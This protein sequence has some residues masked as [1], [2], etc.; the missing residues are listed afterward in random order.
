M[1]RIAPPILGWVVPA[2]TVFL[3][4][5]QA[6]IVYD[7]TS[8]TTTNYFLF[9]RQYG[10]EIN[11]AGTLRNVSEFTFLYFGSIP[12][13]VTSPGEWQIRIYDQNGSLTGDRDRRPGNI[14]WESATFPVLRGYQT[15]TLS[16]PLVAVPDRITWT[17]EFRNLPQQSGNGAGLI[18][19]DPPTIGALLP[20][21]FR[22]VIG[23]YTDY[24]VQQTAGND[25][26]WALNRFSANPFVGPQGN[27]YV[28]VSA[29]PEPSVLAL[30]VLGA[31]GAG[32]WLRR[33][34]NS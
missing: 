32:W 22:P 10:D 29:V 23:S 25:D 31:V 9:S 28:R 7:N 5:A 15:N 11:L 13:G 1:L 17:V 19:A 34:R 30:T 3:A 20:G 12:S 21:N 18:L 16:I 24:W 4:S 27:F 6:E 26:S 2:V 14:L 8:G 33:S